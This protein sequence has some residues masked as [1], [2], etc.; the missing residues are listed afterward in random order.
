M[1]KRRAK[2]SPEMEKNI[3]TI[4]KKIELISALIFDIEEEALQA[5]YVLGF[6]PVKIKALLLKNEYD[7]KG[8]NEVTIRLLEE[9]EILMKK[10]QDDYEI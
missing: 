2:L 4:F 5:E 8:Y 1:A 6:E 10:F 7:I 3:S 9:Y